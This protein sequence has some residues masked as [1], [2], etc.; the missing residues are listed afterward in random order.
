MKI[1][2]AALV[3]LRKWPFWGVGLSAL[4]AGGCSS[5][6]QASQELIAVEAA[7][8]D[9]PDLA[10]LGAKV[11]ATL[12][13]FAETFQRYD[14]QT[15]AANL[16]E[17]YSDQAFLNDRIHTLRGREAIID[18]FLASLD[19]IHAAEFVI[20]DTVLGR[21]DAYVRWVMKIQTA[22]DEPFLAFSGISQ[23]KFDTK[24]QIAFHQDYWDMSELM[25]EV[26]VAGGIVS[27]LKGLF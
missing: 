21:K 22:A 2:S 5:A 26:P 13:L 18:Y 24:G 27:W 6:Q 11:P 15:L 23:L 8:A 1:P 17:L 4:L 19:K 12:A 10:D 14:Q 9:S 7:L 25:A 3:L 16:P 20:Q